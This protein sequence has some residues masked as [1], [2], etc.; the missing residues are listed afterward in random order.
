MFVILSKIVKATGFLI[1]K[2]KREKSK[3]VRTT[4]NIAAVVERVREAPST[5]IHRRYQQLNISEYLRE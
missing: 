3:A 5:S 1:G 2:L 4:E